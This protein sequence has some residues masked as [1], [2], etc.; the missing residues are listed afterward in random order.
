MAKTRY[1]DN[2]TFLLSAAHLTN[3]PPDFG[4][5]VA[6]IGRSN[7]G[8]SSAINIIAGIKRLARVGKTPGVTQLINVFL[9]DQNKRLI[10]LPG[11]GYAKVPGAI[12]ENWHKLVNGY[13]EQRQSLRGLFLLM[14]SRHPLGEN[15][16][17]LLNWAV[18]SKLPL[19]ILLTKA[20]KLKRAEA[21]AVL[22]KVQEEV[23]QHSDLVTVLLFSAQERTGLNEV[24]KQLDRWLKT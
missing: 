11:F 1:S 24:F 14:D 2:V 23:K 15:D 16:L 17:E 7:V 13:L 19:C 18:E 4:S 22:K 20:D 10:D 8:K 21:N 6:F 5:E 3:L 9:I 12:Q